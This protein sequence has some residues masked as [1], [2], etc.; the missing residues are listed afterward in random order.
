[1]D[2]IIKGVLKMFERKYDFKYYWNE[3]IKVLIVIK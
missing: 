3:M 2:E 1:M